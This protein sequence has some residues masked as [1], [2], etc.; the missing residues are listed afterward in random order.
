MKQ[1]KK[2]TTN[3]VSSNESETATTSKQSKVSTNSK[4]IKKP[5]RKAQ[6]TKEKVKDKLD[7]ND[8]DSLKENKRIKAEPTKDQSSSDEFEDVEDIDS[9]P[10][11]KTKSKPKPTK[12]APPQKAKSENLL[13]DIDLMLR[14]E[15]QSKVSRSNPNKSMT[16]N[17]EDESDF[18]EVEMDKGEEHL[19]EVLQRKTSIEV[20]VQSKKDKKKVDMKAK[21]ERMFKA[22]QKQLRIITI[23]T[24]I[25]CWLTHGLYL[26]KMCSDPEIIALALS[27]ESKFQ[28][29]KFQLINFNRKNLC[30]L[31]A[32]INK[33]IFCE[34]NNEK[35]NQS[36]LITQES[37]AKAISEMKCEN[38]LQYYL[39]A[40][41]ILRNQSI[42]SRLCILYLFIRS[43]QTRTKLFL[44]IRKKLEW[45]SFFLNYFI[46]GRKMALGSDS[47]LAL[48]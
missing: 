42:K 24:H 6:L 3:L 28:L 1:K 20:S 18:E 26:N 48:P 13:D 44:R 4:S 37:L 39:L 19:N 32:K 9:E 31:L 23:K 22:A 10:E 35:F 2:S 25:V 38:F 36:S 21:M 40:L 30:E 12:S 45:E 33:N 27:F 47:V 11:K 14:R 41:I 17:H 43:L 15:I 5:T 7:E 34:T 8:D 46:L 16:D 29:K